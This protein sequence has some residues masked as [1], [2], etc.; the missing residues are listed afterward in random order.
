MTARIDAALAA[1]AEERETIR[2]EY[3]ALAAFDRRVADLS[4]VT[5]STGPPLVADP[6]PSGR[7]LTRLRT[8]YAETVMSTPHYET[9]YGDTVAESLAAE[10]GE[11]LAAALIGG[12]ALT[13]EL[14]DAVRAATE[15][16][17]HEREEFLDVLDREADSL[18]TTAD[19]VE[20]IASRLDSLD[21]RPLPARSFDD[22]HDLWST[23][24]DLEAQVDGIGL[25]RQETIRGHRND[26]PGVPT[27]LSEYLYQDL[28]TSYPVLA[29]LADL[30]DRLADTRRRVERA[31][32]TT[33]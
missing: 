20:D 21:G 12:T 10:F 11:D 28:P 7:A 33:P 24:G 2:D 27:D 13:P 19:D 5:V 15:A 17:R 3:E 4:T 8:A 18:A 14:R 9:A 23:L 6:Q 31:L 32:A 30:G 16:A 29:S 22:L 25:R 26:L 1:V